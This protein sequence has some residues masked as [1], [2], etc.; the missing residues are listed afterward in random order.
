MAMLF[1]IGVLGAFGGKILWI[2]EASSFAESL[3][4]RS[5]LET[6]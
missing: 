4:P 3:K 6:V 5:L 1:I 2:R